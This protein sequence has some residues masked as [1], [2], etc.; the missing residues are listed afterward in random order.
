MFV[1]NS[2]SLSAILLLSEFYFR[3]KW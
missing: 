2:P 1:S 3:K